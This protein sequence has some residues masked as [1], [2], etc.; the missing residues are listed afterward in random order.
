MFIESSIDH[1]PIHQHFIARPSHI[2]AGAG[3]MAIPATLEDAISQSLICSSQGQQCGPDQLCVDSKGV[4]RVQHQAESVSNRLL[5]RKQVTLREFLRNFG[6]LFLTGGN[7]RK[8]GDQKDRALYNADIIPCMLHDCDGVH[9]DAEAWEAF[10]KKVILAKQASGFVAAG[11]E[12]SRD[13]KRLRASDPGLHN[14]SAPS[15]PASLAKLPSSSTLA[16]Q[17]ESVSRSPRCR[18]KREGGRDQYDHPSTWFDVTSDSLTGTV[19]QISPPPPPPS[20][21]GLQARMFSPC[22]WHSK[23]GV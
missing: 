13:A 9:V 4:L 10:K 2:E 21:S 20:H 1:P 3:P 7:G 12:A 19:K 16:S 15:T 6:V 11:R 5:G 8:E 14:L 22:C 23:I 17:E 18:I